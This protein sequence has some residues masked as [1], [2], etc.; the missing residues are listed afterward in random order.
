M[1]FPR[2]SWKSGHLAQNYLA[3]FTAG[4]REHPCPADASHK[5]E[6]L[7][8]FPF[9]QLTP[10]PRSFPAPGADGDGRHTT[11]APATYSR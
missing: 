2:R 4:S 8:T 11:A 9:E 5:A 7:V 3:E 6:L 10:V 1:T